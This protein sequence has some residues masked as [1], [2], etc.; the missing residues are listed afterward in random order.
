LEQKRVDPS[1]P[2][3]LRD[4]FLSKAPE[5]RRIPRRK[6]EL[7]QQITVT[8]WSAALPRRFLHGRQLFVGSC[9]I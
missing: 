7:S 4:S 1:Q 8:F 2:I 3:T 5:H 9:V 6:L